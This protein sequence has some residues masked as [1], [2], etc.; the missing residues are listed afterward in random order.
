MS[1][2]QFTAALRHAANTQVRRDAELLLDKLVLSAVGAFQE[3]GIKK[4]ASVITAGTATSAGRTVQLSEKFRSMGEKQG[5]TRLIITED[6]L[7][8]MFKVLNISTPNTN[9]AALYLEF[10]AKKFGNYHLRHFEI[11]M[12]DG[13]IIEEKTSKPIKTLV[14]SI[15]LQNVIAVRGLNFSHRNTLEH[16]ANFLTSINAFPGKNKKDVEKIL[17]GFYDRGHVYAQTTGRAMVSLQDL[18]NEDNI[19]N[20]I[21]RLYKLLDQGSTSLNRLDGKYGEL[22]A[23]CEKD[24]SGSRLFM[25]IQ[26]QL[27]R[28]ESGTGNR[29]T[30]DIS[31]YIRIVKLLQDLIANTSLSS[32][33]KRLLSTPAAQSLKQF[34]KVLVDFDKKLTKYNKEIA[35]VL[36]RTSEPDYLLKLQSSDSLESFINNNMLN[37]LNTGKSKQLKVDTGNISVVKSAKLNSKVDSGYSKAKQNVSRLKTDLNNLKKQLVTTKTTSGIDQKALINLSSLQNILNASLHDRIR[38]NMGTGDRSDVLNYRTGRLAKSARVERLTQSRAGMIT[39]FYTY[40]KNPY[41]TFSA[42][43]RQESPKSRDPKLLIS[44]SIREIA[45]E[46][47]YNRM[48]AVLV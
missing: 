13:S 34:E 35:A 42:G 27:K 5:R 41:A 7:K 11:Y 40:M 16:V 6:D 15:D 20:E 17:G 14:E 22:L 30:G 31:S 9:P 43:G 23:R 47:A 45:Q 26:L 46:Q 29:D 36:S 44:K 19:L 1:I 38:S 24:F 32:D 33:G 2:S 28:D 8:E 39:A 4:A 12:R 37:L 18:Q 21:L 10:L 25:N 48:R 3:G